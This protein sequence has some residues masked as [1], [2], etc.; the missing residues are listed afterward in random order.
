MKKNIMKNIDKI[1]SNV[2]NI[3]GAMKKSMIVI[4]GLI[5]CLSASVNLKAEMDDPEIGDLIFY[6]WDSSWM[7]VPSFFGS[8]DHVAIYVGDS[9]IVEAG[10]NEANTVHSMD[11]DESV[12]REFC[13]G[14]T[15][16][17]LRPWEE[18]QELSDGR[19]N[20]EEDRAE[21]IQYVAE[22]TIAQID[23]PYETSGGAWYKIINSEIGP[24]DSEGNPEE[25]FCT[26]LVWAG[27]MW[28]SAKYGGIV[29]NPYE[30]VPD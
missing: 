16:Y 2:G 18:L 12:N 25:Y 1:I 9:Q 27:Y 6:E 17:R 7:D 19:I 20:S 11:F 21:L 14:Y 13:E 23:H 22:F 29:G 5:I 8:W 24:V 10:M 26:E 3:Y 30:D 28:G 4:L 15:L